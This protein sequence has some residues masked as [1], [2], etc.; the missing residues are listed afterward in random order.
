MVKVEVKWWEAGV[1]QESYWAPNIEAEIDML[2]HLVLR[3]QLCNNPFFG[4]SSHLR[5]TIGLGFIGPLVKEILVREQVL[6]GV[7]RLLWRI[8]RSQPGTT[9]ARNPGIGAE[10]RERLYLCI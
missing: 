10:A 5:G 9:F 6:V 1:D 7:R 8:W 2:A 4:S 3:N